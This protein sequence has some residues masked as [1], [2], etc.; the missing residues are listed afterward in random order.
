[1][2]TSQSLRNNKSDH[3]YR[4]NT[5]NIARLNDNNFIRYR[6]SRKVVERLVFLLDKNQKDIINYHTPNNTIEIASNLSTPTVSH[7]TK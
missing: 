6:H 1:M 4:S 2:H 7:T 5:I 3:I